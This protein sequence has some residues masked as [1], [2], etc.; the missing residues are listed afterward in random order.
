M[1]KNVIKSPLPLSLAIATLLSS[2]YMVT[3]MVLF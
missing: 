2:S 3:I 1:A